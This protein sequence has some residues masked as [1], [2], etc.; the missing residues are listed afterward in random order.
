MQTSAVILSEDSD[1]DLTLNK[2]IDK[3]TKKTDLNENVSKIPRWI[4]KFHMCNLKI[5]VS[6]VWK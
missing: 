3:H 6:Y 2:L 4:L 5:E 1:D